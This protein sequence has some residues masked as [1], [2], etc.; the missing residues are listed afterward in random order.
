MPRHHDR[1]DGSPTLTRLVKKHLKKVIEQ[2]REASVEKRESARSETFTKRA[3]KAIELGYQ[4]ALR[5]HQKHLQPAHLLFGLVAEEEGVAA[6]ALRHLDV[7]LSQVRVV[8]EQLPEQ[9]AQGSMQEMHLSASAQTVID[10]AL[11]EMHHL[12]HRFLGTE[13]LLL[14]LTMCE[15]EQEVDELLEKLNI[16]TEQIRTQ[17]INLLEH[18]TPTSGQGPSQ[19]TTASKV[20]GNVVMCR[21]DDNDLTAVDML[22]EAGI[23]TTRSDAASWLIHAGI[24]ANQSLFQKMSATVAE[25]QRL[26]ELAQSLVDETTQSSSDDLSQH[27]NSASQQDTE[28]H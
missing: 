7:S 21:L 11:N 9:G 22:V 18:L 24:Q 25:I 28:E 14:G 23:R 1:P 8:V 19:G 15:G 12:H 17:V 3:Y 27:F 16:T 6:M 5:L 4:E 10:L 13:H 2:A 20:K 26:R